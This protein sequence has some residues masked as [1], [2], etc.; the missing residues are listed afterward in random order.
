[1]PEPALTLTY[2]RKVPIFTICR[3]APPMDVDRISHGG[4]FGFP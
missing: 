4:W 3:S 1:M 2:D